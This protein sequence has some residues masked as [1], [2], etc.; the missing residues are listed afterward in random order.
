MNLFGFSKKEKD[1][2]MSIVIPG[3]K[4]G[5]KVDD[6][7]LKKATAIYIDQHSR[8]LKESMHLVQTSKNIETQRNRYALA[9]QHSTALAKIQRYADRRQKKV[10]Y[11][12]Q[13]EFMVVKEKY[14]YLQ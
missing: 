5:V 6:K 2:W 13:N 14:H 3:I 8:I 1:N 7:I 4:S 11:D 12:I 9:M 10:I